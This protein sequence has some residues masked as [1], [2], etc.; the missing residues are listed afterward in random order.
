MDT[1]IEDR[2]WISTASVEY[3]LVRPGEELPADAIVSVPSIVP[4]WDLAMRPIDPDS[5]K[6]TLHA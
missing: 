3:W 2:H 5:E 6:G 4:G 1:P